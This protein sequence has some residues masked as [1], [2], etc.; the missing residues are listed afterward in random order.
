VL[1]GADGLDGTLVAAEDDNTWTVGDP[2]TTFRRAL[3][4]DGT[5]PPFANGSECL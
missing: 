5:A 3:A 4:N 1:A 2:P